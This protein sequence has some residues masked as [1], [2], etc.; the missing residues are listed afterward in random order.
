MKKRIFI[1][2]AAMVMVSLSACGG[3]KKEESV[4]AVSET[5]GAAGTVGAVTHE[6]LET[7]KAA[8]PEDI[9]RITY[10]IESEGGAVS[11]EITDADD[12]KLVY[13]MLKDIEPGEKATVSATDSVL[14]IQVEMKGQTFGVRFEYDN[15][16]IGQ[17]EYVAVNLGPLRSYLTDQ[18]KAANEETYMEET[19]GQVK[20]EVDESAE[21]IDISEIINQGGMEA[22]QEYTGYEGVWVPFCRDYQ[23]YL[24]KNWTQI[25]LSQDDINQGVIFGM[26]NMGGDPVIGDVQVK[27]SIMHY[28]METPMS[29]KEIYESFVTAE[30]DAE[31]FDINGLPC[32]FVLDDENGVMDITFVDTVDSGCLYEVTVDV[33]DD[34]SDEVANMCAAML[35]TIYPY[36][37]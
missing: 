5:V 29:R 7:I 14:S 27:V 26:Q 30:M 34:R 33:G 12:V 10:T 15:I 20:P 1:L 22:L 4:N 6:G 36:Q 17:E 2:I 8:N 31:M 28:K 32:V 37:E 25:E 23:I 11:G 18:L 9:T 19:G 13:Y 16:V 35:T 21:Q 24:P 3:G